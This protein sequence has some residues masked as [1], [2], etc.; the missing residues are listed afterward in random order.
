MKVLVTGG[1]GFIGS[2]LVDRL[3]SR[4]D[5]VIVIDN[6]ATGRKANLNPL[7]QFHEFGVCNLELKQIF[8]AEKPQLV[9]HL[10]AQTSVHRSV[11]DPDYDGQTN[12]LG[13]LNVISS[14]AMTGVQKLIY[15]SSSAIYG[16]PRYLPV[17]E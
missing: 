2:H 1:A 10:A 8:E 7:A 16:P 9:F 17:D 6:L 11:S 5:R 15:A 13:G 12:I 3:V 4:G 14:C